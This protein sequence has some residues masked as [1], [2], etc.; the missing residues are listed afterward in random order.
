MTEDD[1]KITLYT[2][3]FCGQALMVE[4]FFENHEI[5]VETINIDGDTEARQRLIELNNGYASVPTVIFPDGT[6]MTEPSLHQIQGRLGMEP[7]SL[8]DRLRNLFD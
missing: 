4:R 3:N 5:P 2:S 6:Q 7:E 8:T 1:E